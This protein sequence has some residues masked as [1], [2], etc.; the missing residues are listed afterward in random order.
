MEIDWN[1]GTAASRRDPAQGGENLV[2]TWKIWARHEYGSLMK[3]Y[4]AV[5]DAWDGMATINNISRWERGTRRIPPHVI[6]HMIGQLLPV[7]MAESSDPT[8][9]QAR[10]RLPQGG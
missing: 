3:A 9:I 6:N 4:E 8:F 5:N 10:L 1:E 2:T 7:L